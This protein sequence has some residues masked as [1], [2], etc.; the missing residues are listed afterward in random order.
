M[1]C[2]YSISR[3]QTVFL[4][5]PLIFPSAPS[6]SGNCEDKAL[7]FYRQG[8]VLLPACRVDCQGVSFGWRGWSFFRNLVVGRGLWRR[9][10]LQRG[11]TIISIGGSLR[12]AKRIRGMIFSMPLEEARSRRL[13]RFVKSCGGGHWIAGAGGNRF[14]PSAI[15]FREKFLISGNVRP[16]D[17]NRH[18]HEYRKIQHVPEI[19]FEGFRPSM[20]L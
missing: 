7:L 4:S 8:A 10:M 13:S 18:G 9:V 5:E 14:C 20:I 19:V 2:H 12:T 11:S 1:P 17:R 16:E 6:R 3:G 15:G